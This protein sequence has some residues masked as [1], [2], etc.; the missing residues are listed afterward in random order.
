MANKLLICCSTVTLVCYFIFALIIIVLFIVEW[1]KGQYE[2]GYFLDVYQNLNQ[3]PIKNIK[4]ITDE[5]ICSNLFTEENPIFWWK[6]KCFYIER[7]NFNYLKLLEKTNDSMEIG[8]DS[9]G[10]KLYSIEKAINFIQITN[11][12]TPSINKYS[13]QI[14]TQQIDSE[15]F[16]HYSNDY[17][18]NQVLVDIKIGTEKKPCDD[19]KK[20]KSLDIS[21]Y[22]CKDRD[23]D[24]GNTFTKLDETILNDYDNK[25]KN[26]NHKIYLYKRTYIGAPSNYNEYNDLEG[27]KNYAQYKIKIIIILY[28][29]SVIFNNENSDSNENSNNTG[30]SKFCKFCKFIC[31]SVFPIIKIRI[32]L[33]CIHNYEIYQKFFFSTLNHGIKYYYTN[34]I[35]FINIDKTILAFEI[36]SLIPCIVIIGSILIFCLGGLGILGKEVIDKMAEKIKEREE[37]KKR[38]KQ[39]KEEIKKLEN[40]PNIPQYKINLKR[41]EFFKE[42]FMDALTCPISLEIFRDPVIV[43][44]GHTYEREYIKKIIEENGKDPLTRENLDKDKIIGN[45]LVEKLIQEFNSGINFDENTYYKM[46]E[47]LKCPISQKIFINPYLASVGNKGMTYEKVYIENYIDENKN[48]PTFNVPIKGYLIKNYVIQDMVDSINE[49]NKN[50]KNFSIVLIEDEK[51]D[52]NIDTKDKIN[53][54]INHINNANN[55]NNNINNDIISEKV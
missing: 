47:L 11:S 24:P 5:K 1:K 26:K 17:I 14:I 41:L 27:I 32:I 9:L 15:T 22:K 29:I 35:W 31:N 51:N 49:M 34:S 20:I 28:I 54:D 25:A 2:D 16:L 3:T 55:D 36:I 46:V 6:G 48:D 42:K 12:Q 21:E 4:V 40:N 52:A 43:S 44:N 7:I 23:L 50:K 33:K 39:Y 45:Y 13:N 18:E 30:C 19:I 8:Y 37:R 38:I 53:D 10:N